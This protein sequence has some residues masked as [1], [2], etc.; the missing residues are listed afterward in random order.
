MVGPFPVW[1]IWIISGVFLL[2]LEIFTPGF[3]VSLIGFASILAGISAI[4]FPNFY[5]NVSVFII[6]LIIIIIFL[7]PVFLKMFYKKSAYIPDTFVDSIIGKEV[8]VD[9][10]IDNLKGLGYIKVGADYF[11][12]KSAN[13]TNIPKGDVVEILSMEGITATVKKKI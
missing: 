11:K 2:I 10:D 7:R 4:F 3:V 13:G 9:S 5:F 8:L 1:F 6:T 12:A